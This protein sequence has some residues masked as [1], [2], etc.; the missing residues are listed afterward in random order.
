M[1]AKFRFIPHVVFSSPAECACIFPNNFHLFLVQSLDDR[2][3]SSIVAVALATSE[4]PMSLQQKIN[5][6]QTNDN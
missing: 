5:N 6:K 4:A 2:A 1:K 3:V